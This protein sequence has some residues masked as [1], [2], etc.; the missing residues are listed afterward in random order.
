[1]ERSTSV[2][3]RA[4]QGTTPYHPQ[5]C[6]L[7][8][9]MEDSASLACQTGQSARALLR[10]HVSGHENGLPTIH[11]IFNAVLMHPTV[12]LPTGAAPTPSAT[13]CDSFARDV[14]VSQRLDLPSPLQCNSCMIKY[15]PFQPH[16]FSRCCQL[17]AEPP[18]LMRLPPC[19]DLTNRT[20]R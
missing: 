16:V 11:Y 3:C 2:A 9:N 1:M 8:G 20:R 10:A 18:N 7:S 15:H 17:P 19:C 4:G 13:R 14:T 6:Q 12:R 5:S